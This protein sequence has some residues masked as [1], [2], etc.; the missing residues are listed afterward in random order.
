MEEMW[1]RGE[2]TARQV[3]EALNQGRPKPRAYTTVMTTMRR[4]HRKGLLNRERHGKADLYAPRISRVEYRNARVRVE[5]EALVDEFGAVAL[6][7]FSAQVARLDPER[8]RRLREL[9]EE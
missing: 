9:A 6:A 2:A 5:V 3:L 1:L 8:V 7:H 4:L